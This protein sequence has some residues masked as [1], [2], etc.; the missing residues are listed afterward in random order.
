MCR[1]YRARQRRSH[2]DDI[3][4]SFECIVKGTLGRQVRYRYKFKLGLKL[5]GKYALDSIA[6]GRFSNNTTD[7]VS[8]FKSGYQCCVGNEP[9]DSG[10]L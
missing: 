9:A 7:T 10:D 5:G 2:M 1:T 4:H 3:G 6:L 8:R